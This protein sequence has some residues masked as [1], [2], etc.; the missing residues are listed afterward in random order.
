MQAEDLVLDEGGEGEKIEEVGEVFPHVRVAVLS[1]AFVVKSIDLRDLAGLVISS[2]DSDTL[3]ITDLKA[4]KE[5]DR[6]DG[7]VATVDIVA[8]L[9]LA[10]DLQQERTTYP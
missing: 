1:K 6:L 2:E 9:K 8:L 7:V 3:G 4:H 10:R 5:R